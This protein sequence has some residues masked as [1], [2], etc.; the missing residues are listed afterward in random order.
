VLSDDYQGSWR[1]GKLVS[2]VEDWSLVRCE[3]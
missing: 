1:S 3:F 2:L